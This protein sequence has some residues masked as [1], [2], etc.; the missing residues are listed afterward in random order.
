[1]QFFKDSLAIIFEG[2]WP[3]VGRKGLVPDIR[4]RVHGSPVTIGYA[5]TGYRVGK[6]DR[7]CCFAAV[8][9]K[10]PTTRARKGRPLDGRFVFPNSSFLSPTRS[11]P[12]NRSVFD[13]YVSRPFAVRIFYYNNTY[14]TR[15]RRRQ[16][17]ISLIRFFFFLSY[18]S[19]FPNAITRVTRGFYVKHQR[20][21]MNYYR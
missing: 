14:A 1:M 17:T 21:F 16:R 5:S 20:K 18:S 15:F 3:A 8:R 19:S 9:E 6:H 7:P 11:G 2:G 12:D 13:F 4:Q 10:M